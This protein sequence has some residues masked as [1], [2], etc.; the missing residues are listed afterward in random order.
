MSAPSCRAL[1]AQIAR[2]EDLFIH[3]HGQQPKCA[4]ERAP[5]A[6]MYAQYQ[7]QKCAIRVDS[8]SW[9]QA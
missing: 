1:R 2:F 6:T 3:L 4:L 5:L 8:A 7:E 9:I